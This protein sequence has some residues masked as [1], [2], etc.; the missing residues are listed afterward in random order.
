MSK[1]SA[2]LTAVS[3]AQSVG[4]YGYE[5]I[6]PSPCGKRLHSVRKK[7]PQSALQRASRKKNRRNK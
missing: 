7:R 5:T 6:N 2:L 3:F 1:I 4:G